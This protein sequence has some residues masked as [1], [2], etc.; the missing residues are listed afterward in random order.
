MELASIGPL[1]DI[2]ENTAAAV[3]AGMLLGGFA[4]GLMGL[5]QAWP[6]RAIDHGVMQ[7][8]YYGGAGGL[9]ILAVDMMF[10]HAV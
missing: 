10:H 3:A 6:R 9:A 5:V 2:L 8:G 7:F 4:T 1:T